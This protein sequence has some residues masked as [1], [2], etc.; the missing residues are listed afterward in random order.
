MIDIMMDV[1]GGHKMKV[2]FYKFPSKL[3]DS[4]YDS[5]ELSDYSFEHIKDYNFVECWYYYGSGDCC[6]AGNFIAQDKEGKYYLTDL[7]HCSCYGPLNSDGR[8]F[9]VFDTLDDM[10]KA[11]SKEYYSKEIKYLINKIRK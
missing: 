5:C 8:D 11:C 2:H 1:M 7:G 4:H 3:Y 6:G 10:I 9:R